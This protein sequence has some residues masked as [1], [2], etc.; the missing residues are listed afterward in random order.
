MNAIPSQLLFYRAYI[1]AA[2]LASLIVYVLF[3]PPVHPFNGKLLDTVTDVLGLASVLSGELSRVWALSYSGEATRSRYLNAPVLVTT[4]P[5]AFSRNP[6]CLGDLLTGWGLILLSEAFVFIIPFL[7]LFTFLYHRIV[8]EEEALLDEKFG[9]A[10]RHYWL[11]VPRWIPK[12]SSPEGEFGFGAKFPIKELRRALAMGV[13]AFF[14]EGMKSP[15]HHN[16]FASLLE[17]IFRNF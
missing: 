12:L 7:V 6:M 15:L 16:W 4:G 2:F 5:Y 10:Y 1:Q 11:A 17:E 8:L 13:S 3:V 14:F 9:A